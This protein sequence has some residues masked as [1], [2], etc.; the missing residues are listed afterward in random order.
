MSKTWYQPLVSFCPPPEKFRLSGRFLMLWMAGVYVS[1]SLEDPMF[2]CSFSSSPH[3]PGHHSDPERGSADSSGAD[4]VFLLSESEFWF[5]EKE[6]AVVNLPCPPFPFP[7]FFCCEC[8][9]EPSSGFI[10][11]LLSRSGPLCSSWQISRLC[12]VISWMSWSALSTGLDKIT[13]WAPLLSEFSSAL[14]GH[15]LIFVF[16]GSLRGGRFQEA[17]CECV[18]WGTGREH[19]VWVPAARE[20]RLQVQFVIF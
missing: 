1:S 2:I 17:L 11:L 20:G 9:A 5:K 10:Y 4:P 14:M 16:R 19:G 3:P 18:L 7:F 13:S 8:V 15:S 12:P 6:I